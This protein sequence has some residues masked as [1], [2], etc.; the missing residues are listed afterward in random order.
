MKK[1]NV[2]SACI[3]LAVSALVVGGYHFSQDGSGSKAMVQVV[4]G[5]N[6]HMLY[7]KNEEGEITP[8]D[9]TQTTDK[10]LDAVVHIKS[11]GTRTM[12]SGMGQNY[13]DLPDP[14]KE[15]FKDRGLQRYFDSPEG[16]QMPGEDAQEKGLLGMGS[17]VIINEEGYVVTNNHVI[18]GADE[19]VVTLNDNQSYPASVIGIDPTTDIALLQIQAKDLHALSL[20]NSDDVKVG[21][22]VLAIGNPFS[23]NSTVTAGIVSAK[24]RNININK[25][26]F[27]VES[28][29]QTDAA[30]NPGNSGGALVNLNGDLIGI[31]TAIASTTGS[32]NGYGFA[33]PSNMVAKVVED[34]LK[35][36][37]VQRGVLGVSIRTM[38]SDLAKEREMD[39]VPGVY[40]NE[41]GE[42]SAAGKAGIKVGDVIIAVDG[43]KVTTSPL[44]Q[45]L[46]A[47]H[48]PGDRVTIKVNRH[49]KEQLLHVVLQN[50]D[51]NKEVH[52]L[53]NGRL[54]GTLGID[55]KKLD[56]EESQKLGL[57]GGVKIE[58]LFAGKI[59]RETQMAEGFII[60]HVDGKKVGSVDELVNAI[61]GKKGG[62]MLQG[63]YP[64]NPE[65]K[66]YAFSMDAE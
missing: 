19:I 43:T 39:F 7:T 2:M 27:A 1:S 10:V 35:Y 64:G 36:G 25:D 54:L 37:D 44:L 48:R 20:V 51:G 11:M 9:F 22:W 13:R 26:Q 47:R 5:N 60:T 32:Y 42:Q 15:F 6:P 31:N 8:L 24:A 33:V 23:L 34:L 63:V 58:R 52:T 29:I 65:K 17:G 59:K 28:F 12:G 49:G 45:E 40:V 16:Q 38:D 57:D 3:A 18:N 55:P 62:V 4:D 50:R 53:K 56:Q 30:I 66:Y 14:F 46:I 21:E 61:D 41:V